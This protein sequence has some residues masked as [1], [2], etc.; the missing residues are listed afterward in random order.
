VTRD[1]F[2]KGN[3]VLGGEGSPHVSKYGQRDSIFIAG[4]GYQEGGEYRIVRQVADPN[5]NEVFPGQMG[6]L[7]KVGKQYA[8]IA[9]VKVYFLDS[10]SAVADVEFSCQPVVPG[11]LVIPSQAR[12]VPQ[13]PVRPEFKRFIHESGDNAGRIIQANDFDYFL[14]AG[15]KVYLNMGSDKV[16]PGDYVRISRS[17]QAKEMPPVDRLVFKA[18]TYEDTQKDPGVLTNADMKNFPVKGLGE[19]MVISSNANSSTAVITLSLEDIH[20]GDTVEVVR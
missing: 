13:Y 9:L 6:M 14:G 17:F 16:K 7:K 11:D 18:K 10:K 1:S 3:F 2:N 20:I 15:Q 12:E 4:S 8:D 19:A 5:K